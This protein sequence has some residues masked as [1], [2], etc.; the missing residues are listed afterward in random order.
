MENNT[1]RKKSRSFV[2]HEPTKVLVAADDR[3]LLELAIEHL[4]TPTASVE[5]A[6]E[7]AA[8]WS[9]LKARDFDIAVLDI[10]MPP[11]DGFELLEKIRTDER[12]HHLPVIMLT[13][14]EDIAS[15]DLAY[16]L[17]ANSFVTKPVNWRLLSYHI[18][19]VLRMSRLEHA[20]NPTV[21]QGDAA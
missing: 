6:A 13:G 1:S 8:A 11:R 17:G 18:R 10:G 5:T 16:A 4:S 7:G 21:R 15:I 20:L 12:L 9:M 2:L 3:S 19:Y 14:Q